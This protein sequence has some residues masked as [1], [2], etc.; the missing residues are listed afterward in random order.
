MT[1]SRIPLGALG[2]WGIATGR[3]V[4]AITLLCV[5]ATVDLFDGVISR[6]RGEETAARRTLDVIVD[7][8]AIHSAVVVM[9]II[10]DFGWALPLLLV[11]RD[12]VQAAYSANLVRKYRRVRLSGSAM[13]TSLIAAKGRLRRTIK[14]SCTGSY[15]CSKRILSE[16]FLCSP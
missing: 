8:T 9:T 1:A 15:R 4:F 5:F 3:T 6:R 10:N 2:M 14:K 16:V 13:K 12:M 11:S 7:R